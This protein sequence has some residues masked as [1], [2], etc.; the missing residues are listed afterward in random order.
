MS[1]AAASR[2]IRRR[3][4]ATWWPFWAAA[5]GVAATLLIVWSMLHPRR[6]PV[7]A[8]L[9]EGAPA[10][11][12]LDRTVLRREPSSGSASVATLAAGARITT[13]PDRGRWVRVD[14]D[15][16][17]GYLPADAI[18]RDADRDARERLAKRLLALPAVYGVV[19][20]DADV[21]LA[22]YP[23]AS[24][25]GRITRGTVIEIHSVDHGYFAF[26]DKSLGIAFVNSAAVD[27][28]P[29]DPHQPELSPEKVRPLKNLTVV[30][31]S[32]SPPPDDEELAAE[33]ENG[34]PEPR[35]PAAGARP[36]PPPA[37]SVSDA[38]PG[39]I[40]PAAVATR[41]EPSYPDLAR[42]AGVEG[43][44]ELEVA[45]DAGGKVSEVEVLR[46][47]PMGLSDAAVDAVRRWT[48]KPA[49][50]P[51]GPVASRR[52]VRIRFML[53]GADR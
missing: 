3:R 36:A 4:P 31:L 13:G 33:M 5:A 11:V 32:T 51:Q 7:P 28:V 17:S 12:T 39:L 27:I 16:K 52:T 1:E 14:A 24:R 30:D 15:G 8:A 46:G 29:P 9:E 6:E 35:P 43:T 20:D 50:S 42:R 53:S 49:R 25:A 2:P 45:I 37:A 47:L 23:L 40:E 44:V 26:R 48:W 21:T 10:S 19:S 34:P 38:A 22:P 18:E 41:V